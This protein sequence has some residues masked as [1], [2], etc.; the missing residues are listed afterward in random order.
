MRQET[1]PFDSPKKKDI[2]FLNSH[3]QL[4]RPMENKFYPFDR[5]SAR[6]EKTQVDVSVVM[7][8]YNEGDIVEEVLLDWNQGL[9]EM[10]LNYEII[11]I[12]DGSLDGTGRVLDKL[13]R[14]IPQLRVIHQLNTGHSQAIRRGYSLARGQ[15]I[16]QCD[17]N[18]RYEPEDFSRLWEA[19]ANHRMV[20]AHRTHRLDSFPR[21][22]FSNFLKRITHWIF[23]V[24]LQDPNVPFRLFKK[25]P[26]NDF[27]KVLPIHWKNIN[28]ALS[29]YVST[30][31]PQRIVEV[32]IPFRKRA[33]G[34]SSTSTYD[35]INLSFECLGEMLSLRKL[36]KNQNF[37]PSP[38]PVRAL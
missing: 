4:T 36:L 30:N 22:L 15:Y 35:L 12:N 11:V 26:L 7:P 16:L 8:V 1:L 13:R 23:R 33:L 34:K 20:V 2:I 21:R 6:S 17:L 37:N 24:K 10:G 9:L 3:S 19:K 28:L 25:E 32:K 5:I 27:M 18:G 14:E 29:I 31:T 38:V